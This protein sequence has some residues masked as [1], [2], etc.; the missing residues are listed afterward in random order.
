MSTTPSREATPRT[1]G[2][3]ALGSMMTGPVEVSTAAHATDGVTMKPASIELEDGT[4]LEGMSFGHDEPVAGEVVFNTGM[5]GYTETL[6]DPSYAGQILVATY[7]LVGNYGVP[8]DAR[9]F[10]LSTRYESTRIQVAGLVV[11]DYSPS[12]SHWDAARSLGDWLRSEK[13]PAITGIDTRSLTQH[14]RE[15]GSMLGRIRIES[16]SAEYRDPNAE[17][18]VRRVSI[19]EPQLFEGQRELRI[20]LIDTGAKSNI[21]HCLLNRD[22]GVLRVPWDYPLADDRF[23]GV[24]LS[25][26]PGD[27]AMA[28]KTVE[29]VRWAIDRGKPLFGI[30][31]GNQLL[32]RAIGAETYKLKYGH[33]GQNQ[34]VI[35]CGTNRCFVTSQNHGFA[36]D[37]ASLPSDWRPWFEN[38]NDRTNEGLRHAWAPFR[39][40]QFHPEAAPGPVDTAF[41]FDDFVRMVAHHRQ[42]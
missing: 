19:T 17:N 9:S 21:V 34:P 8:R 25:N 27:P 15:R 24:M 29:Q 32:A 36:V 38:L 11:A 23:D 2:P 26:G 6:T 31:L 3:S 28:E 40:V 20:V 1:H 18:L 42:Q 13:I 7:P 30:C 16:R 5:V 12:Y 4:V 33:R 10:G 37:T 14:L 22:V 39:S 35:E 41:L